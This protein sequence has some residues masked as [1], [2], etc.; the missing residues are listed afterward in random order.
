MII[1]LQSKSN[2]EYEFI[3]L[4]NKLSIVVI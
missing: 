4:L 3:R 2:N 1:K